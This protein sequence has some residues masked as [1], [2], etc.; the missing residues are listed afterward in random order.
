[1]HFLYINIIRSESLISRCHR[2]QQSRATQN[3][4]YTPIR[5][6][7]GIQQEAGETLQKLYRDQEGANYGQLPS[8]KKGNIHMHI[9]YKII[10]HQ[11]H[12]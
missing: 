3:L 6:T 2:P 11:A 1:M 10:H 4:C 5:R 8:R 7:E 12:N 9:I